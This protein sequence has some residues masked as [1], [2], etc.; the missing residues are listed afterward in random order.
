MRVVSDLIEEKYL[1]KLPHILVAA[2][3]LVISSGMAGLVYH[4]RADRP[5]TTPVSTTPSVVVFETTECDLCESFRSKIG[6]P[7][8]S[9]AFGA[10]VP[11]RYYDVT[12]GQPP[13]S[14]KLAGGIGHTPTTVVFDVYG[15]EVKR[16]GGVPKSLDEFQGIL[17]PFVRRA[18]KDLADAQTRTTR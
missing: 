2:A 1:D 4:A 12:D 6:K 11:L 15:R 7:H 10:Q 5:A 16:L 18:E 17:K 13:K 8:R 14:F 9:S 3:L